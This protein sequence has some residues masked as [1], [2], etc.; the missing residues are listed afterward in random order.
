MIAPSD[1]EKSYGVTGLP[2]GFLIDKN[3]K[4][5]DKFIGFSPSVANQLDSKVQ[6]LLSENPS[7]FAGEFDLSQELPTLFCL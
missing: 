1:L 7:F 3:G 2:T 5:R 6:T 4:I